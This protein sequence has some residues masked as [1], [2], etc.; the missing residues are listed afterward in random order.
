[1]K[2]ST[3]KTTL[4]AV[5][6][7]GATLRGPHQ[8]VDDPRLPSE[9]RGHPPGGRRDVGK[10]NDEHQHPEHRARSCR[11]CCRQRSAA[12]ST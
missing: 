10:G 8:A 5:T 12:A 2:P 1:M 3:E 9:L 6:F 7:G 4:P 11:A